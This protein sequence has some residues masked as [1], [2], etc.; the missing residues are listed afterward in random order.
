M[1]KEFKTKDFR[2]A[3]FL[4]SKQQPYL[5]IF[6]SS[7]DKTVCEFKFE[8]KDI[9]NYLE[10]WNNPQTEGIRKLLRSVTFLKSELKRFYS[11]RTN[12]YDKTAH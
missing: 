1:D 5:G 9:V 10:Q 7:D 3:A 2:L 4:H 12:D 6:P 11:I 8:S